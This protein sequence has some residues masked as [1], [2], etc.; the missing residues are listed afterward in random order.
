MSH[1]C[2]TYIMLRE[3]KVK[4]AK[5]IKYVFKDI[6]C[7][8]HVRVKISRVFSTNFDFRTSSWIQEKFVEKF[9]LGSTYCPT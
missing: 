4:L 2:H 8:V 3:E 1:S 6:K 5:L 9:E 7:T